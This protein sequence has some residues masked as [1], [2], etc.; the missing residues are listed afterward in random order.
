[1]Y[2]LP[3]IS[4]T[5]IPEIRV[6]PE[7]L[8]VFC[9]IDVLTCMIYNCTRLNISKDIDTILPTLDESKRTNR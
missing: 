5:L 7:I 3:R 9:C 4:R 1:M 2:H 8:C 6:R